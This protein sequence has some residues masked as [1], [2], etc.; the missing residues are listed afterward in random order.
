MKV[1]G[2]FIFCL[3]PSLK[4]LIE[5]T[6]CILNSYRISDCMFESRIMSAYIFCGQAAS[7]S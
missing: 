4:Q 5:A 7:V 2:Y 3:G 6:A 1:I